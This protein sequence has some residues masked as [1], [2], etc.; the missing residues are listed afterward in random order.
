[1]LQIFEKWM[2]LPSVHIDLGEHI[3]GHI[4]VLHKLFYFFVCL[5]LLTPKLVAGES[6]DPQATL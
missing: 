6:K 5:W 4:F 3:E 2:L 1:M